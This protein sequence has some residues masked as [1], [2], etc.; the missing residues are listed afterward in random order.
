MTRISLLDDNHDTWVNQVRAAREKGAPLTAQE[1]GRILA[2]R[3]W[4]DTPQLS[5]EEL[6]SRTQQ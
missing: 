4:R 6:A 3:H 5:D 2:G 1:R